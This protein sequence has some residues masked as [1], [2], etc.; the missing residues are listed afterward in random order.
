MN[1]LANK[2]PAFKTPLNTTF[3]PLIGE[4]L[5]YFLP[6][7]YDPEGNDLPEVYV[8][9]SASTEFAYPPYLFFNN[10]TNSLTFRP[11]S[12][13]YQGVTFVFDVIIKESSSNHTY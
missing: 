13:W 9:Y 2:G 4:V 3:E 8:D 12:I 1:I 11:H 6:K 10:I 5:E 7:L